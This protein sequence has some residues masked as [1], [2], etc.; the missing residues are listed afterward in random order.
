MQV[1]DVLSELSC[2][3]EYYGINIDQTG[4]KMSALNPFLP[5]LFK[6]EKC[7]LMPYS[8]LIFAS[9]IKLPFFLYCFPNSG[10]EKFKLW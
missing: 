4:T 5:G 8:I 10:K 1:S 3:I 6:T 2:V 9:V 7:A